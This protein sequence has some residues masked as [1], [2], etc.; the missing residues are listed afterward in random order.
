[1]GRAGSPEKISFIVNELGFDAGINYKTGILSDMLADACPL[2]IDVYFDNVGGQITDVVIEQINT[3]ARI[4]VCG[5]ISQYNLEQP[6]PGPRNMGA[7][8]VN[9]AKMEGFLVSKFA[10]RFEEARLRIAGGIRQGKI[11]YKEDIV[12]GIENA[13]S[14]FMGMLRG[15]NFGKMLIHVAND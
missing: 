15:E 2:G 8:V 14:A 11:Q 13:P 5:Q 3:G 4:S 6:E 1:M 10:N 12:E 7:L 9:Q